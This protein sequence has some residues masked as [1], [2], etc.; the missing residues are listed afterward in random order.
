M[1][2]VEP[3]SLSVISTV[4]RV[5][6]VC[7]KTKWSK[8]SKTQVEQIEALLKM[9]TVSENRKIFDDFSAKMVGRI[10]DRLAPLKKLNKLSSVAHISKAVE[11][12]S[13]S[14]HEERIWAL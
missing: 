8:R 5:L 1:V 14:F 6:E 2:S 13:T 10:D 9:I 7:K 4:E 12:L 11:K 3:V